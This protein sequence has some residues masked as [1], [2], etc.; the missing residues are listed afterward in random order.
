MSGIPG[1]DIPVDGAFPQVCLTGQYMGW[2]DLFY[3]IS[4]YAWSY[5]GIGIAMGLSIFGAAW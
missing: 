1:T 5:I 2:K 3:C 4:P